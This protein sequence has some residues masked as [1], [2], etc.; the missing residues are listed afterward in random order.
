MDLLS[1]LVLTLTLVA[2]NNDD[3]RAGRH[4]FNDPG[5]GTHG[6]ACANCHATVADENADGDGLIRSGH[7]LYGAAQRPFWRG[8]R[9]RKVHENLSTAVDVCSELFQGSPPL[10]GQDRLQLHAYLASLGGSAKTRP[11]E[12]Q[13]SL[14]SDLNYDRPKYK[15]GRPKQGRALFY[16]S[17]HGCHPNGGAGIA[18]AVLALPIARVIEKLREGNGL[19]RGKQV[20]GEWSPFF[21]KD[22]LS[23]QQAA[24]IA[25]WIVSQETKAP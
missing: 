9:D 13:P 10:K 14:E 20:A 11:I 25:A 23:D 2:A 17:C 3:V 6:V 24:D 22:R 5:L 1:P 8:D 12:I 15:T 4:L 18:P 16:Q 19:L 7:T 21:G